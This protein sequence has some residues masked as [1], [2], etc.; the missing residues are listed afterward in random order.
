MNDIPK[1]TKSA[2]LGLETVEQCLRFG[3]TTDSARRMVIDSGPDKIAPDPMDLLLVAIA[4]CQSMDV[5]SILRKRHQHVTGYD[6][7][8]VGER[9]PE[10]PKAYTRIEI[11]HRVT[12]HDVSLAA[13]EEAAELSHTRYCS[14]QNSLD[15]RIE[16][17]HRCEVIPA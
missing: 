8:I 2:R 16:F 10:H 6:V 7:S 12:G 13:V 9:R 5:I 15:P 17:V 3:A 11:V 4:A 14:V 1:K